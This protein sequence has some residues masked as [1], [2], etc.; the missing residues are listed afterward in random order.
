M[1]ENDKLITAFSKSNGK[2]L[3]LESKIIPHS[4]VEVIQKAYEALWKRL[5]IRLPESWLQKRTVTMNY[6][7]LLSICKQRSGHK[8]TEWHTFI[9]WVHT[10]PYANEFVFLNENL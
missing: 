1:S 10:L 3:E 5:I 8:L 2:D 6:E 9:D 4:Q 7:N